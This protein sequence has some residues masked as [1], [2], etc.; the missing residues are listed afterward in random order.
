MTTADKNANSMLRQRAEGVVQRGAERREIGL[1]QLSPGAMQQ[2][3]HELRVHQ[4]EL[5]MQND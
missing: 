4:I 5:E 3:I 2:T 1:E